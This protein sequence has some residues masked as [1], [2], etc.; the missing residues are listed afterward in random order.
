MK[1]GE[2]I[3]KLSELDPDEEI[4]L[5]DSEDGA[6]KIMNLGRTPEW[7]SP[8]APIVWAVMAYDC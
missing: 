3:E 7:Q 1:V 5:E 8:S 6:L 2:L 4:Y